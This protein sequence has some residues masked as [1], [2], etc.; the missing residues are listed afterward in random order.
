MIFGRQPAFWI[1]LIV[2]IVLGI[3]R[4]L[5]GEGLISDAAT[6][7]VTSAVNAIGELAL[8]VAPL[9]TGLLIQPNVTPVAAPKLPANTEVMVQGTNDT[10]VIQP[11]P[12]GPVGIED[13]AADGDQPVGGPIGGA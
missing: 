11:T 3:V 7:Q 13:G 4:T 2:T 10:V 5:A 1:G 6:G 8:L 9:V 12:P